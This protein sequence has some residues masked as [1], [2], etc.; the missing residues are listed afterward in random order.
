[1]LLTDSV[2]EQ[3]FSL[4]FDMWVD[5][6]VR[7]GNRAFFFFLFSKSFF[8]LVAIPTCYLAKPKR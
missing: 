3:F 2:F 8:Y 5:A 1:M 6:G 4:L 7:E